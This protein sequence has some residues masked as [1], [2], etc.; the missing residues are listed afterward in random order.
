MAK[1]EIFTLAHK[2]AKQI[3]LTGSYSI[4]LSMALKAAYR[5]AELGDKMNKATHVQFYMDGTFSLSSGTTAFHG[6]ETLIN[7]FFL[8]S[9]ID[10]QE[11]ESQRFTRLAIERYNK[12]KAA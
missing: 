8:D 3:N 2:L 10:F 11:T 1:S 12:S 4:R 6:W 9:V 7:G 5:I